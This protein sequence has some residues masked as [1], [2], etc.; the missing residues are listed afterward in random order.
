MTNLLIL[1]KDHLLQ[2]M[3]I[4]FLVNI[5]FHYLWLNKLNKTPRQ[6]ALLLVSATLVFVVILLYVTINNL[7]ALAQ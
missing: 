7:S 6:L 3:M 4:F 1:L 2:I 5:V